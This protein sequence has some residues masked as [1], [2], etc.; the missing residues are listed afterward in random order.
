MTDGEKAGE[1]RKSMVDSV[2]GKAKEI[3]GA[4]TG[5]DSLTAEGQLQQAEAKERRDAAKSEAEAD[6]EAAEAISLAD[7]AKREASKGRLGAGADAAAVIQRVR[8]EQTVAKSA[9][10]EAGNR[11]AVQEQA[12]AE[13]DAQRDIVRA[14]VDERAEVEAAAQEYSDAVDEHRHS[15]S[16][17]V[18]TQ[19]QAN[20]AR[21]LA[22]TIE[23]TDDRS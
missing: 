6:A 11:E 5:N 21:R 4:V 13:T 19:A 7:D 16:D 20:Q 18:R 17:A 12:K 9:A 23:H 8:G 15:V 10:D 3:A 2:K 22:E 1:A 14:K